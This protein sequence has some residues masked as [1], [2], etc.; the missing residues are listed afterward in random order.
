V[1]L[2]RF[3]TLISSNDK[4]IDQFVIIFRIDS[5]RNNSSGLI[6]SS[7]TAT[8]TAAAKRHQRHQHRQPT[9]NSNSGTG[10]GTGS[11][12]ATAAPAAKRHQ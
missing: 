8:A 2:T 5:S 7:E 11:E 9:G 6:G 4:S 1:W 3:L 12:T 10:T